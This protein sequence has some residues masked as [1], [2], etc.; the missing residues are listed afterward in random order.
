MS[1]E[2]RSSL[3]EV[4]TG[5]RKTIAAISTPSTQGH[6][7]L[8]LTA[9]IALVTGIV[10]L[11]IDLPLILMAVL[12]VVSLAALALF[13]IGARARF[14]PASSLHAE[15]TPAP[16]RSAN[17]TG[18]TPGKI[19]VPYLR[20]TRSM[21]N[22]TDRGDM[23]ILA[24]CLAAIGAGYVTLFVDLPLALLVFTGIVTLTTL[25]TIGLATAF[26]FAPEKMVAMLTDRYPAT[27][28]PSGI[29]RPGD[30][31]LPVVVPCPVSAELPEKSGGGILD[32]YWVQP[33]F[34]YIRIAQQGNLGFIY[35]VVEPAMTTREKIILQETYN[36][37]RDIII[38]DNP[39]KSPSDM[40][41]RESIYRILRENDP[42]IAPE[43]FPVLEYFLHRDLSGFGL[44]EP[45]MH[46][47]ALEDISCNGDDLPVYVFH[48]TYG[49]LR[50]SVL[51]RKGE[52][53]QYVL[54]LAQKANKQIS[55]SN[56][57]VDAALP[58]G[59][60]V[61]V[62]YS[63]VIS[64]NGSSFT[65]RKFR[66]EPL[67]PLDLIKF[68]TYSSEI[69]AFLWLVIEHRRSLIIAGGTA[70]GK[71]STMNAIS[72][73]IPLNSKIV[74]LEDT[75][76]IQLPHK[77][78]LATQTRELNIPGHG[79]VNL[80]SLLKSSM[81]QRPEY[82]IVGEVRGE[83]AQTLFQ[84][85]NTGHATLSTIHAG[86]VQETINRLTHEPIN[87]PPVMFTALDLVVNQAVF[88]FGSLRVRRCSAIN[89]IS[90]DEKGDIIPVKLFEWDTSAQQFCK[91]RAR[92][93]V[94]DEIA[95]MRNWS[96]EQVAE[97]LKRREEFLNIAVDVP[98]PDIIDLA[99]AIQDLG[100]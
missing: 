18:K 25:A 94:L 49:S 51:F 85:M 17:T 15:D 75:R 47:P 95:M 92:S 86:S 64:T 54:K 23:L 28:S 69:L 99:N 19:I 9:T 32:V 52:L 6:L 21:G 11:F 42:T 31:P 97:E 62:T 34:A 93:N 63:N 89:E 37:L 53:N 44:L 30:P 58:D 26:R 72:L 48:R 59:S 38:F 27:P 68:G 14:F 40:L 3:G 33:P 2:F 29:V 88:T 96:D 39:E 87:V 41:N 20:L 81:R 57:M 50:T 84:A 55:L 5:Y 7:L 78:W 12:S 67:T 77:N 35:T 10:V 79:D 100:D 61:Q 90:V 82:I 74:S 73:F 56:P 13:A 8:L 83:E 46:D 60:R 65:V 4:G 22:R 66:A 70:S 36:Y 45:L 76:E 91:T 24:C 71:T 1:P 16:V 98:P 43:R 80:F